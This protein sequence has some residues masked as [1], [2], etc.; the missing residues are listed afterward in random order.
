MERSFEAER[1]WIGRSSSANFREI[2][3]S[4]K[5]RAGV[6]VTE[7]D[8][9]PLNAG[10]ALSEMRWPSASMGEALSANAA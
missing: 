10:F 7:L 3:S 2:S 4:L 6:E 9:V 8:E 1:W 5:S